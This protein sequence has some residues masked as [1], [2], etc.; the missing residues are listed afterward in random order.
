MSKLFLS[1]FVYA[2]RNKEEWIAYLNISK[3]TFDFM[4]SFEDERK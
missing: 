4:G 2:V 1:I 3:E